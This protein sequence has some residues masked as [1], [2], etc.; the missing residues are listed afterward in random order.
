MVPVELGREAAHRL[1]AEELARQDY[2]RDDPGLVERALDW[3]LDR[4]GQLFGTVDRASGGHALL[5]LTLL[6]LVAALGAVALRA[7]LGPVA[8]SARAAEPLFDAEV[9]DAAGHRRR[10]DEHAAA[11]RFELAVRERLRAVV[12]GLEERGLLDVRPG[13]TVDEAA[14]EAGAALPS[15]REGLAAAAATFDDVWYGGRPA[16]ARDDELLRRVDYEVRSARPPIAAP[17]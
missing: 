10:A 2:H 1:A 17:R 15:A 5:A 8:R 13:R 16:L 9:L 6:V 12:R 7:R 14:R 4:I 11:A 3:V